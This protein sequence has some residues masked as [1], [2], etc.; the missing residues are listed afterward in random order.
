MEDHSY[1]E[2]DRYDQSYS[3]E[4]GA[5][6]DDYSDD[7][8]WKQQ[9][10]NK[11]SKKQKRREQRE[12]R[13]GRQDYDDSEEDYSSQNYSSHDYSAK[14]DQEQEQYPQ[15]QESDQYSDSGDSYSEEEADSDQD[16]QPEEVEQPVFVQASAQKDAV[17]N[18]VKD[19]SP[20]NHESLN[21]ENSEDEEDPG[22]SVQ[23]EKAFKKFKDRFMEKVSP[24][25]SAV[26]NK[27]SQFFTRKK[28]EKEDLID[29]AAL[30][31]IQETAEETGKEI[32]AEIESSLKRNWKRIRKQTVGVTAVSTL[33]LSAISG[34][35]FFLKEDPEEVAARKVSMEETSA[36]EDLEG[37]FKKP[38]ELL[39]K[40][41]VQ[42]QGGEKKPGSGGPLRETAKDRTPLPP[43]NDLKNKLDNFIGSVDQ[44]VKKDANA[45][46]Q[47]IKKKAGELDQTIQKEVKKV[48]QFIEKEIK[49]PVKDIVDK[50]SKELE[51][52]K[53][54]SGVN[55]EFNPNGPGTVKINP[56]VKKP[57]DPFAQ[58]KPADKKT[59]TLPLPNEKKLTIPLAA[60]SGKERPNTSR[61]MLPLQAVKPAPAPGASQVPAAV[62]NQIDKV[63][64][65]VSETVNNAVRKAEEIKADLAGQ[66][67]LVLPPQGLK[68]QTPP[69]NRMLLNNTANTSSPAPQPPA[70]LG[71]AFPAAGANQSL[72][73]SAN[74][75]GSL[76]PN[77]PSSGAPVP[78]P[79]PQGTSSLP[80]AANNTGQL[81]PASA[82]SFGQSPNPGSL[83]PLTMQNPAPNS[84][85]LS[86][87]QMNP[88]DS[89]G[90]PVR[91]QT[92]A[93]P[94]NSGQQGASF[95]PLQPLGSASAPSAPSGSLNMPQSISGT[96]S[97]A[98]GS[99]APSNP[100]VP[101]SAN[102][103][104]PYSGMNTTGQTQASSNQYRIY[105]TREGDNLLSI[106]GG[107]LG[108]PMRW[109]E[110]KRLNPEPVSRLNL[111]NPV[112]PAGTQ[113]YLP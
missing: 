58:N 4:D 62:S 31:K 16:N 82:S 103:A 53:G 87:L 65:A 106:A 50:T 9:K 17:S 47:T 95:V 10:N 33:V 101:Y 75:A 81:S 69:E 59:A 37:V 76:V 77:S 72:L 102:Q 29:D 83:Q 79:L 93:S 92:S 78:S 5:D 63:N 48:D 46:D 85:S 49:K 64:T 21:D 6:L 43:P 100:G 80:T 20:K 35:M 67:Q 26:K 36:V 70:A 23:R 30:E 56:E 55:V 7:Q 45:I 28:E 86:N 84:G 88:A 66:K 42:L 34:A 105:T 99:A 111:E 14:E 107:E 74:T 97:V 18:S 25:L 19:P 15:E 90:M 96:P 94:V 2:D 38:G 8:S 108:D 3:E 51:K 11:K 13:R 41:P 1:E 98:I 109:V 39:S 52:T 27:T 22:E 110:I 89:Q 54:L 91:I 44:K 73:P 113:L 57:I 32:T 40:I 12:M 68:P 104:A 61:E 24:A 71:S 112:F 60:P